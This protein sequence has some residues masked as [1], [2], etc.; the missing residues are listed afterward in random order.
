MTAESRGARW[1]RLSPHLERA[2]D[3]T[4]EERAGFLEG[5]ALPWG[6]PSFASR[7]MGA[8][9]LR[10][11]LGQGGMGSVW[12]AER[13]DARWPEPRLRDRDPRRRWYRRLARHAARR[14]PGLGERHPRRPPGTGPCA[15]FS[16]DITSL[17]LSIPSGNVWIGVRW[18]PTLFPSRFLCADQSVATT[19]RRGFVNFNPRQRLAGDRNGFLQLSGEPDPRHPGAGGRGR[20]R[21]F[22]TRRVFLVARV[23]DPP[24]KLV[25]LQVAEL[26]NAA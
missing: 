20:F 23:H 22:G 11:L 17:G 4:G 7:V 1:R 21:P 2:L 24:W 8:Y 16:Y 18:N 14:A 6:S 9:R 5:A 26:L 25:G 15:F 3:L 10:T 12:L 13:A 19:H